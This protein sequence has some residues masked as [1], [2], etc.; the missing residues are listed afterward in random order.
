MKIVVFGAS[1]KTGSLLVEQAL[2]E[3]HN[4]IAY[5]RSA[6]SIKSENSNLEVVVGNLNEKDKLKKA[7]TGADACISTL[8]GGSLT[9]HNPAIIEG[10]DFI[11]SIMEEAGVPRFIYMSSIGVG[12][13]RYFMPQP[14]RFLVVD[15]MLRV[16]MADHHINEQRIAKS[17]LKWTVIRPGSLTD[18]SQTGNLKHGCEKT[19]LTGNA[20][21]SRANVAA[22]ILSQL[23]TN[24]YMNKSV[25]LHE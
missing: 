5:V 9:K 20:S 4:V 6:G 3:G 21:I 1:G 24:Q 7:I 13:S 2:K 10:I 16:P 11:V 18:K 12:D 8:G 19:K 17:K 15:V 23:A 14:I 25:W 22:F